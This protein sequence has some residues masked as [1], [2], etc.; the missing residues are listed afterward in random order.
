MEGPAL[1]P[2]EPDAVFDHPFSHTLKRLTEIALIEHD[3]TSTLIPPIQPCHRLI[4]IRK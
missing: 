2:R 1:F 3:A 4:S